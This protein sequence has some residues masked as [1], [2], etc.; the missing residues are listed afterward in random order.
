VGGI[1]WNGV[2]V[3]VASGGTCTKDPGVVWMEIGAAAMEVLPNPGIPQD[4]QKNITSSRIKGNW[5]GDFFIIRV[6]S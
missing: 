5:L 1:G 3:G 4:V 6:Y 2:A